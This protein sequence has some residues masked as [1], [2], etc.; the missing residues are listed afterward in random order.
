MFKIASWRSSTHGSGTRPGRAGARQAATGTAL[1]VLAGVLAAL[2]LTPDRAVSPPR[3]VPRPVVVLDP[4]HGGVDGGTHWQER[5]LEK[6]LT[7]QLAR[8]MEALLTASGYRVVLTRTGDYA[9]APGWDDAS[10]RRDLE[11]RLRITREAGA[12]VL[13]SLHINAASDRSMRGPIVFYQDGDEAGRRLAGHIQA[14]L[15]AVFPAGARNEALPA[16]FFLLAKA[17]RPSVLI[18]FAFLTNARDRELLVTPAGQQRLAAAAVRGLVA[19]LQAA[20]RRPGEAPGGKAAP[21]PA[22]TAS[23]GPP[24]GLPGRR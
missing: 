12:V 17:G 9:L 24:G 20:V 22:G 7:L 10:V 11:E 13:V 18:E 21:A 6:D 8:R 2:L 4:G 3:A 5:V 16:D 15:N 14:A 23:P 19:G 1:L